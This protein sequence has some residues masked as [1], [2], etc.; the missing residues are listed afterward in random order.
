MEAIKDYIKKMQEESNNIKNKQIIDDI[1][2]ISKGLYNTYDDYVKH[3]S[4]R[5]LIVP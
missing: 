1:I 5:K 4:L 3:I 2:D